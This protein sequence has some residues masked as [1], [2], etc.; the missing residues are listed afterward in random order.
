VYLQQWNEPCLPLLPSRRT[1]P[2]FGLCSFSITLRI[3]GRVGLGVDLAGCVRIGAM[4]VRGRSPVSRNTN[5]ARCR[6]TWSFGLCRVIKLC[7]LMHLRLPSH[8][9]SSYPPHCV[10]GA[11]TSR[12][13][14]SDRISTDLI[15]SELSGSGCVLNRPG[16]FTV[17]V[18]DQ[19]R[20][21][22]FLSDLSQPWRTGSHSL[23]SSSDEM[24][25]VEMR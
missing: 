11:F 20:S 9:N 21:K 14:S 22:S 7:A 12:L 25:S 10:E 24:G 15:S 18:T 16:Q 13:I 23:T 19:N 6:A 1:S 3:G 8:L 4:P 2:P 17:A 5:R